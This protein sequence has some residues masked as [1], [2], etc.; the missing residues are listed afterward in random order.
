MLN[1]TL[2]TIL[3]ILSS[4]GSQPLDAASSGLVQRD[5][6]QAELVADV[7]SVQPG[8]DLR[9]GLR[10]VP[11]PG[12]HTYWKNPGD[13]GLA[14]TI[15][16]T[17]PAGVSASEIAWPYPDAI[18]FAHLINYGYDGEHLLP[19]TLS[20]PGDLPIDRP[21]RLEARA[22]WLVCEEIC[23]PGDATLVLELPVSDQEP[24]MDSAAAEWFAW[25]DARRPEA[26]D[27]PARF[28]TESGQLSV[29]VESEAIGSAR[30]WE[31]FSE[32]NNLVDHSSPPV[33]NA[34]NGQL[35]VAQAL[36]P[37]VNRFPESLDF[38]LVDR[39][40]NR[41]F[42][43]NAGVGELVSTGEPSSTTAPTAPPIGWMRA[44]GLA[45]LGGLL[46]NL[47]PCVFPVLSIKA[48]SLVEGAGSDQR[49]HGLAYTAGVV[50]SFVALAAV[51]LAL[52]SVGEGV[53]WGF[54]LQSPWIVGLL[55]YVLFAMG[56]SLSGLFSLGG[57]FMNVGQ[58]LTE[59]SGVSGS[60][61]TG[62]LACIVASPCTAPGMA[63]AL[64][65]AVLMD[66][67][68]ALSIFAALGFGLALPLLL[69]SFSPALARWL[70]RPGPW[71]D[72]F[73]QLMAFP[74]YLA[75][76]WLVWVLARQTDANGLAAVLIGLVALA[77]TLWLIGKKDGGPVVS[78][79]R[80]VSVVAGVVVA[81]AALAA[82]ARFE[83]DPTETADA[84]W[85]DYSAARLAELRQDPDTA[86]FVNMTADWCLT[87]KV[88]EGVAL[89]KDQVREAF[90]A[91]NVVYMK[92]DWTRR[93]AAI[94]DYLADFG[95]NGVPLYVVYPHDGGEPQILPQVLTPGLV[96]NVVESL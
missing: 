2:I 39:P 9:V 64:G 42:R 36:S 4:L 45:L 17:L 91:E 27:W 89:N 63:A 21:L 59:R 6:L 87:C 43:L 60:F 62:V 77:F 53:G 93:D 1:R 40:N 26:V 28:S 44:L 73:K 75:V 29:Q 5:H 16:W 54:Q 68:M 38:V 69:L 47:M 70:P 25:A 67:P 85:E 46:L 30:G 33:L 19:V 34:G 14:T 8:T 41:A 49:A 10:L 79:A 80:H 56:L 61:F 22:D 78:V 35:L 32:D 57:G 7:D 51:M 11:D 31:F 88:N 12:W 13:S 94:T 24:V 84:W 15:E 3:L 72:T 52:R 71:M 58:G 48:I 95:R 55:I 83:S 86:V 50:L 90:E 96:I 65:A 37:F 23:I 81:L 76:V 82:A 66:W 74:L 20:I 18:P 92:G